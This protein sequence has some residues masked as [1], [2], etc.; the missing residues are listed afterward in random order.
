[1]QPDYRFELYDQNQ[2]LILDLTA[3]ARD[4][5]FSL[6]RNGVDEISF[7]LDLRKFEEIARSIKYHPRELLKQ[8]SAD[9]KVKRNDKYLVGAEIISTPGSISGDTVTLQV[10]CAGYLNMFKD[11]YITKT[12]TQV[13]RAEIA[14]DMIAWTQQGGTGSYI[15]IRDFGVRPGPN[16]VASTVPSDRGLVRQ[17]IKDEIMNST[18]LITGRYDFEFTPFRLFNTYTNIGSIRDD[19]LIEYPGNVVSASIDGDGSTIA[20]E[21]TG[22]GSGLGA[23]ALSSTVLDTLSASDRKVRQ[24]IV[25]FNNVQLQSTVDEKTYGE[26]RRL[27]DVLRIPRVTVNG[28]NFDLGIIGRGDIVPV[29]ISTLDFYDDLYQYLRI[30]KLEVSLD[31]N[32]NES[33]VLTLDDFDY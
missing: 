20:N 14:R 19:F 32:N 23:E 9:V 30:E 4:R 8:L 18:E 2:K 3:I 15:P 22:L 5:K 24:K 25:T 11:R 27:K 17:N 12:Y 6:V 28:V 31:E 10:R 1:M 16:Q 29:K 33:I 26:V 13:D 21:I 7:T